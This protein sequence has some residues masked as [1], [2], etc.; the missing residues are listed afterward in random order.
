MQEIYLTF[1]Y[2]N[3][4]SYK[5]FRCYLNIRH[6]LHVTQYKQQLHVTYCNNAY[7][8]GIKKLLH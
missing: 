5:K 8:Y 3:L 4:V 6:N 2:L 7:A 1:T